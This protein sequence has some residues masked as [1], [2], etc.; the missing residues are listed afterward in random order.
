MLHK[1]EAGLFDSRT[2]EER[3]R[4]RDAKR[5]AQVDNSD[6]PPPLRRS[7]ALQDPNK[8]S[9]GKLPRR[10]PPSPRPSDVFSGVVN[11]VKG[12]VQDGIK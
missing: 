7:Y 2:P 12:V 3:K 8:K 6:L 10:A 5:Q 1:D 4:D 11:G 9:G